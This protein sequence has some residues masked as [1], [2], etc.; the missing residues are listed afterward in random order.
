M[1]FIHLFALWVFSGYEYMLG[2]FGA[3]RSARD[4]MLSG[5]IL[6]QREMVVD[7]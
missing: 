7:G 3:G 1:S 5:A 4:L 2:L 6:S